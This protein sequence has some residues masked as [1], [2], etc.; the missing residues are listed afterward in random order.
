MF[1]TPAKLLNTVNLFTF[2][3]CLHVFYSTF[4]LRDR[5]TRARNIERQYP[6]DVNTVGELCAGVFVKAEEIEPWCG[7]DI[8][9][10]HPDGLTDI[11]MCFP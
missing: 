7:L 2:K 8:N 1:S 9:Q 5:C 11:L 3:Q 4:S 6:P 10:I